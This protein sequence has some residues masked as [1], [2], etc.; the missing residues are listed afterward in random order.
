MRPNVRMAGSMAAGGGEEEPSAVDVF[1]RARNAGTQAMG[2]MIGEGVGQMAQA[3]AQ[4]LLIQ[5]RD[6]VRKDLIKRMPRGATFGSSAPMFQPRDNS[7]A[8]GAIGSALKE[9]VSPS[10]RPAASPGVGAKPFWQPSGDDGWGSTPLG[11]R[12]SDE[13]ML[14]KAIAGFSFL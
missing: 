13:S 1:S 4:G 3:K 12:G 11:A 8:F 9:I 14:S 2:Q 5:E 10:A 7:A 6:K